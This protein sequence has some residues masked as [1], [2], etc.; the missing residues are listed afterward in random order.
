MV[1]HPK[2]PGDL[3][4]QTPL[5]A[6]NHLKNNA[7]RIP[8][9]ITFNIPY[10]KTLQGIRAGHNDSQDY[11]PLPLESIKEIRAYTGIKKNLSTH[12]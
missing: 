12:S 5:L 6:S 1:S 9:N 11:S 7:I 4:F 2:F 3:L 10:L 8:K